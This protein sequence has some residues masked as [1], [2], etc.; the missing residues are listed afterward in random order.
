MST[1]APQSKESRVQALAAAAA[2]LAVKDAAADFAKNGLNANV[3]QTVGPSE[4]KCREPTSS[5]LNS[6]SV[7]NVGNDITI[8]ASGAGRDRNISV[9][10]SDLNAQ[11]NITLKADN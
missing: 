10:G 8:R 2:A 3:S 1:A 7:V 9:I 4:S 6:G 11:G 5:L